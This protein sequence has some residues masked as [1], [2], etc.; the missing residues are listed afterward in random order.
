MAET[1]LY[2]AA[3]RPYPTRDALGV[4]LVAVEELA[5]E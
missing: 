4:D 3:P 5:D 2:G 1:D